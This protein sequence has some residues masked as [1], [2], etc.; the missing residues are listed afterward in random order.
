MYYLYK[1]RIEINTKRVVKWFA[2]AAM[3]YYC[4]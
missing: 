2:F 3:D 1:G 4:C